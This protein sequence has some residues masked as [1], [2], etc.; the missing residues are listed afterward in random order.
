[1]K[2]PR[3][4]G[5]GKCIECKGIGHIKCSYC[6]GT[7][8]KLINLDSGI[9]KYA[10][11]KYCDGKGTVKC[12][13]VCESCEGS[14]EIT[15][16]YQKEVREKYLPVPVKIRE[17][18]SIVSFSILVLN[19]I[20][21]IVTSIGDGLRGHN[22]LFYLGALYSPA[23]IAGQ[24]WRVVTAIFIHIGL[25]HFIMNSY[26]LFILCPPIEKLIGSGKFLLLYLFSG[27]IGNI[28]TVVL[29]PGSI[30]AGAS[31][32]LFGILGAY[33]GLNFRYKIFNSSF[34]NQLVFWLG[35]NI[36]IGFL[37]GLNINI[38]AHLGGLA[39]GILFSLLIKFNE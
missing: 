28:L 21:Y 31:G 25:M 24:W 15:S 13:P 4:E 3:C 8:N 35:L 27:V 20:V 9:S 34:I 32:A 37:P 6:E 7:G 23:V 26:C 14:G 5:T 12:D 29:M 2:C 22:I 36:F 16:Q 30:S 19:L 38:W 11:C 10:K 18:V 39:G 17:A 1:M 33:F